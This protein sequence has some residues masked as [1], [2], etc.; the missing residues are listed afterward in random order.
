MYMQISV[1]PEDRKFLRF[2]WGTTQPD[3]Y[4][5]FV[6]GS[7]EYTR[8]VFGS[9]CSP[10]CANFALQTCGD[11]N[12]IDYPHIQELIDSNFYMGD[13]YESTNTV[14]EVLQLPNDLRKVLATRSFNLAGWITTNSEI[15]SAIPQQHRSIS[16]NEM[17]D[18]KTTT[19]ELEIGWK[20]P[21]K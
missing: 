10:T 4:T 19:G 11:D 1:R 15:L 21:S 6:F 5:R 2:T 3:F 16:Y 13:F 7:N 20:V 14:E 17:K 9:K 8:F 18:P 12:K